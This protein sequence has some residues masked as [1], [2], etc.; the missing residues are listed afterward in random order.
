MSYRRALQDSFYHSNQGYNPLPV[1]SSTLPLQSTPVVQTGKVNAATL[2]VSEFLDLFQKVAREVLSE[3]IRREI[4]S[5]KAPNLPAFKAKISKGNVP[6]GLYEKMDKLGNFELRASANRFRNDNNLSYTGAI[7]YRSLV[8]REFD[9]LVEIIQGSVAQ[10]PASTVASTHPKTFAAV[11]ENFEVV[12]AYIPSLIR[13]NLSPD[14][15]QILNTKLNRLSVQG[16]NFISD[17]QTIV[18]MTMCCFRNSSFGTSNDGQLLLN[19]TQGVPVHNFL[20]EN[21]NSEEAI[22][23]SAPAYSADFLASNVSR[24]LCSLFTDHHVNYLKSGFYGVRGLQAKTKT[25]YPIRSALFNMI[26]DT[27]T[28]FL[29]PKET[30]H[31]ACYESILSTYITNLTVMWNDHKIINAL[32]NKL[33]LVLLRLHLAPAREAKRREYINSQ[34]NKKKDAMQKK[35]EKPHVPFLDQGFVELSSN[36]RRM[37]IQYR[38]DKYERKMKASINNDDKEKWSKRYNDSRIRIDKY[39]TILEKVHFNI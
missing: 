20:P 1:L 39:E 28:Q 25:D 6:R 18:L 14:I 23:Y 19:P 24:E 22:L 31:M 34:L 5:K 17:F 15:K 38:R 11:E 29:Q 32:L 21:F 37:I 12:T 33:I 13:E 36:R 27:V 30:L 7:G 8:E 26:F 2:S 10:T 3:I 35:Q 9:S 16:S 4:K